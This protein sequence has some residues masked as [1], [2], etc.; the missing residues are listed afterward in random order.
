MPLKRRQDWPEQ[1]VRAIKEKQSSKFQYGVHD[2]CLSVCDCVLAMTD[3]DLADKFRGY[4]TSKGA[5]TRLGEHDGLHGLAQHIADEH[6]IVQLV[7]KHARRG[8]VALVD[9][10]KVGETL[11][12]I[13]PSGTQIAVAGKIGWLY[14]PKERGV[15]FWRI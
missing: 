5:K 9:D 11:G 2:C 12:I 15:V 14:L 10:P 3:V 13:E 7:M 6:G 1:L 4:K 8:D